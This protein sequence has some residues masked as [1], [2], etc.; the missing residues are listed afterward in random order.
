MLNRCLSSGGS[1]YFGFF[2]MLFWIVLIILVIWFGVQL[3]SGKNN[4]NPNSYKSHNEYAGDSLALLNERFIC[5]EIT[6]EEYIHKK[7]LLK[8]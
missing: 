2:G 6:E 5:G 3:F 4:A 7:Q 8:K 1:G